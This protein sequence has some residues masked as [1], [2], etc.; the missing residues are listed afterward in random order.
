MTAGGAESI[1]NDQFVTEVVQRLLKALGSGS[2]D[3]PAL[4]GRRPAPARMGP[5]GRWS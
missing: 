1:S 5:P 4:L 2:A 3:R